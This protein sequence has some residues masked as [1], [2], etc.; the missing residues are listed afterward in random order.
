MK[1]LNKKDKKELKQFDY[2]SFQRFLKESKIVIQL[3]HPTSIDIFETHKSHNFDFFLEA[4]PMKLRMQQKN[5]NKKLKNEFSKSQ[6]LNV[7]ILMNCNGNKS[8]F[9]F[10]HRIIF[11]SFFELDF[12][13]FIDL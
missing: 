1:E 12:V 13:F 7:N 5:R 11:M 4:N 8:M 3:R 9:L 2:K 6:H 10:W